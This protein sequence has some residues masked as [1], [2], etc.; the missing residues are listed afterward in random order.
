MAKLTLTLSKAFDRAISVFKAG[1][2][3]EAEQLCQQ[4]INANRDHFGALHLLAVVQSCLDK[5][6]MAL[7]NYDRAVALKPDFAEALSNRGLTLHELKRFEDALA[8]Y[9]RALGL[10]PNLA[11]GHYNRGNTLYAFK[12]FEE[13]LASYDRALA[14]RPDYAEAHHNRGNALKELTRPDEALASYDRALALRPGLCRGAVQ[15]R[16]GAQGL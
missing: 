2:L 7:A 15:S 16:R 13:A 14:I 8:S 4:V 9:D 3:T 6:E 12:P 5:R 10:Q 1:K 11:A